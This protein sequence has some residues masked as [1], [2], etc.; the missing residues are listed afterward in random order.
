[1]GTVCSPSR[2]HVDGQCRAVA[3]L[4]RGNGQSP[5]HHGD[6]SPHSRGSR[7]YTKACR[8]EGIK[9]PHRKDPLCRL[10]SL[11]GDLFQSGNQWSSE[12]PARPY[13]GA[14]LLPHNKSRKDSL[15][16]Q[17]GRPHGNHLFL[18][19]QQFFAH[20]FFPNGD[21]PAQAVHNVIVSHQ[22]LCQG[23]VFHNG[24]IRHF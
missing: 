5:D 4:L 13:A 7:S 21:L 10:A 22:L 15:P 19:S 8:R 11:P 24:R 20:F 23:V 2:T 18:E 12:S 1:M 17:R 9:H 6:N 16:F 3:P 14:T